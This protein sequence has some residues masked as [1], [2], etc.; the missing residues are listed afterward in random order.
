MIVAVVI[1]ATALIFVF[2]KRKADSMSVV[3]PL[4]E[5]VTYIGLAFLLGT[6]VLQ[7]ISEENKPALSIS[8]KWLIGSAS[9]VGIFL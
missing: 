9:A 1:V 6:A 5:W 7:Y 4:F 3:L 8:S 2:R